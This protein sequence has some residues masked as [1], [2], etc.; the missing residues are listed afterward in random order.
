MLR[1]NLLLALAQSP[2]YW[3]TQR[4]GAN[5]FNQ[6]VPVSW[7]EAAAKARIGMVRLAFEKWAPRDFLIGSADRY[8]QLVPAHLKQLVKTLDDFAAHRI[9]VVLVPIT[10]PGCRWRQ[11]NNGRRDDRLWE[12]KSFWPQCARYWRDLSREVAKHPAIVGLDLMNEPDTK[13]P[14][15]PFYDLLIEA[16]R[17]NHSTVPIL[18][19]SSQYGAPPSLPALKPVNDPNVLYSVHMYEPYEYSTWRIN[20][21]KTS[22]PNE[23]ANAAW[24]GQYLD[25]VRAWLKQHNLPPQRL[26]VGEFGCSRR[27]PGAAQY[28]ADLIQIFNREQWHWLFYSFR[29]DTWEGMDYE[30]GA[31]PR[32]FETNR[33]YQPN[34]PIWQAIA[35]KL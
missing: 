32:Y 34:N 19:E 21:G 2:S 33:P 16:I 24:L 13:V 31:V 29:E 20:Q 25:P 22:Y 7:V 17:A 8:T 23:T 6:K 9:G 15:N 12:D 35:S 28:L 3:A 10:M 18:I 5:C 1:R 27:S 4:R 11:S 26:V 30:L 14:L